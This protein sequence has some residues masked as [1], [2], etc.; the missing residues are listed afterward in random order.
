MTLREP[1]AVLDNVLHSH[2]NRHSIDMDSLKQVNIDINSNRITLQ[3][4]NSDA[5]NH[6]S[7]SSNSHQNI[8]TQ[9]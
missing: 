6:N 4:Q 2:V 1:L 9:L 7:Q 8:Q 3:N 5:D